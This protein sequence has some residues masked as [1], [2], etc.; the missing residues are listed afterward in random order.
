MFPCHVCSDVCMCQ[1]RGCTLG[2]F[3]PGE[4]QGTCAAREQ[5]FIAADLDRITI[6]HELASLHVSCKSHVYPEG[7]LTIVIDN[8]SR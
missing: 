3:G 1:V 7:G 6:V 4:R 8:Q 5:G 2:V